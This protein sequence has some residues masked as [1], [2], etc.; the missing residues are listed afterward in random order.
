VIEVA[1][2]A[3]LDPMHQFTIEPLIPLRIGEFDFSFTNSSAWMLITLALIFLFVLLGMKR[4]LVPGRWQMAEA[5]RAAA[6]ENEIMVNAAVMQ[7]NL[8]VEAAERN[9]RNAPGS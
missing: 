3:K 5:R 8:K 1:G 6:R 2:E 4:E 7:T 9:I